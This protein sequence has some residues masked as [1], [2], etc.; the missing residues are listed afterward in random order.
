[1]RPSSSR[2][3]HA[4]QGEHLVHVYYPACSTS[5]WQLEG[6]I[7]VLMGAGSTTD[8]DLARP[9]LDGGRVPPRRGTEQ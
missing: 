9:E 8:S 7:K 6:V 2:S 3:D 5:P 1:M 4:P